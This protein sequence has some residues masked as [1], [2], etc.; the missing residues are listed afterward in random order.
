ML[1]KLIWNKLPEI[2]LC[3]GVSVPNQANISYFPG[4]DR[5]RGDQYCVLMSS[6]LVFSSDKPYIFRMLAMLSK[7]IWNKPPELWLCFGVSVPDQANVSY[8]P[9][10]D[11][12]RGDRYCVLMSSNL[13]FSSDKPYSFRMLAMLGKLVW[14]KPPEIW[15]CF[16]G[17]SSR[18]S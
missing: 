5:K 13:F 7:L 4:W 10:W 9:G 16:G 12:K 14:N 1:S 3:F 2:W 18:S 6:N 8:F 11:R 15:L 17:F